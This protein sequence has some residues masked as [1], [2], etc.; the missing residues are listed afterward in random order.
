M[1]LV[2]SAHPTYQREGRA[3]LSRIRSAPTVHSLL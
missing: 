1:A 3:G 2:G